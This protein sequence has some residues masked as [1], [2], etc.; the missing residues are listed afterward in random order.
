MAYLK[1]NKAELVNLE[2]SLKREIIATNRTGAY[3]NTTIVCCNTRKYHCLLAVPIEQM[4]WRRHALLSSLDETLVQHGKSFNLG[5]HCYGGVFEPRGHKYIVDYQNDPIPTITYHIGGIKL[6]KQ[7]LMVQNEDRVL[8][9]YT[10]LDA[11]SSTTLKLKPLLSFRSIHELTHCNPDADTRCVDIENGKAYKL[12]R[13]L[14]I[15]YLQTS[16]KGEYVVNPDWY[17]GVTYPEEYRRGF[18]CSEDLYSPG[19]FELPIKKGETIIVSAS[20]SPCKPSTFKRKFTNELAA[21]GELTDFDTTIRNAA[22]R[23]FLQRSGR[24]EISS[25]FSWLE[26]GGLRDT[27]ICASGLTLHNNGNVKDF[28]KVLDD[29][30]KKWHDDVLISCRKVEAPLRIATM[31]QEYIEFTGDEK[32]AWNRWGKIVRDILKSFLAGR[33]EV[34]VHENGLLWASMPGYSLSWMNAYTDGKPI[35]ERAGYQVETNAYWYNA[36]M[37]AAAM[38][39]KYS[40]SNKDAARFEETAALV[41]ENYTKMFW[42]ERHCYLADY[43][44]MAGANFDVRPNQLLACSLP[45][46]PLQEEMKHIVVQLVKRELLTARGIRTLS[47]KNP[48]Y[49]GIY[50][51]NQC[52]RDLAYHNGSTRPWLLKHYALACFKLYGASFCRDAA[53]MIAGFE[54][55]M[56]IHGIG[57]IAEIYDGDPPHHPHGAINSATATGAILTVKYLINL[58]KQNSKQL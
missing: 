55:D 25:G 30:I 7:I 56:S 31:V 17:Y 20:T 19:W 14:P 41:K 57:A 23:L 43:V 47:P 46:S 16:K 21:I 27:G 51:G 3:A 13:S 35:T 22:S 39:R 10:L 33:P 44:G 15:L 36:L 34:T 38:E 48:N 32:G 28:A 53:K 54:E 6:Q 58:Y 2:Y 9:R 11:H 40:R 26:I 4:N 18:D 52:Q 42:S 29:I 24:L 50:D 1:F 37:F 49:K 8:I 45:Y 5:I 12:Y